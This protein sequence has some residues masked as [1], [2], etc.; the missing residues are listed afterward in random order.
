MKRWSNRVQAIAQTASIFVVHEHF[1]KFNLLEPSFANFLIEI[2]ILEE[3]VYQPGQK[4]RD[5]LFGV[6]G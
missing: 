2:Q 6:L 4:D 3:P 5:E 1:L